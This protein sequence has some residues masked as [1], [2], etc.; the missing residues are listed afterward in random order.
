VN[1]ATDEL[2]DD[3]AVH[4][5][6][7]D[8]VI[9]YTR[10]TGVRPVNYTFDPPAGVLRNSGEVEPHVVRIRN[11]RHARGLALDVSGFEMIRH[12][13]SLADWNSFTDADRV[14]KFDY[15]EVEAALR[16]HTG[17][18]KVLIFDHTLRDSTAVPGRTALREPVRRVHDD[19]TFD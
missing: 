1:A 7:V 19:Q 12:R 17:A 5:P 13:T 2:I 11:A 10:N 14:R 15:P 9:N 8:A 4:Q 18:D 16:D 3:L 6:Y